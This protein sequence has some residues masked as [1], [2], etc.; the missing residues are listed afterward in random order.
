VL[1]PRRGLRM[2]AAL[3][4]ASLT[5]LVCGPAFAADPTSHATA[6]SL[7]LEVAGTPAVSQNI[8]ADN[9]GSGEQKTGDD[10]LPTIAGVLPEN[11]LLSAGVAPQDAGAND[12]GTSWACAGIAGQGSTG[13]VTTGDGGCSIDGQPVTLDLANLSLGDQLLD[14]DSVVGDAL[15]NIEALDTVLDQITGGVSDALNQATA[16][17]PI[18]L[19]GSLGVVQ[20]ECSATPTSAEGDSFLANTEGDSNPIILTVGDTPITLVDLPV[21]PD[22]NQKVVSGLDG[23]TQAIIDAVNVELGSAL[24]DTPG[25]DL[26]DLLPV[27]VTLATIQTQLIASLTEALQP[28]LQPLEDNV[29]DITL[30]KQTTGDIGRSIDVTA[31]DLQVL[32]A[33]QQFLDVPLISG[34]LGH[35]TCGPNTARTTTPPTGQPGDPADPADNGQPPA[36]G[37]G[38]PPA[39]DPD[40]P[41]AV[42]AGVEGE[43]HDGRD[44]L[45]LGLGGLALAGTAG[46]VVYRRFAAK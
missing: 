17:I 3:G 41:V 8:T 9:D 6:Q 10:T 21:H 11:N 19:T 42:N 43:S 30:N 46:T 2:G 36:P 37:T 22:V 15:G 16:A 18:S 28:V 12:D 23:V 34:Q 27:D 38:N 7:N 32:P 1:S 45:I 13:V 5:V 25:A 39:A 20:A 33:A 14:T 4:A 26:L 44:A 31:I 40:L 29:L 35:V 24:Q